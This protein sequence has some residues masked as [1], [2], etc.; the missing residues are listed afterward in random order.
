M[1]SDV[2]GNN[3][4][5]LGIGVRENVLDQ[6]VAILVTGDID[7]WNAR[8]VETTLTDTIKVATE[9][10]DTTDL[11]ALLNNLGSKLVHA[12]L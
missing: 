7:Q 1:L 5:M 12:I 4:T 10:V 6:I 11:E 9:E 8:T 3:L 2:L